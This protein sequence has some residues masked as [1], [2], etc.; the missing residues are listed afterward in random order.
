MPS[1]LSG[2]QRG[3]ASALPGCGYHGPASFEL[4]RRRIF[5]R[6]WLCLGRA[7]RPVS[8]VISSSS[9]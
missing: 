7:S 5:H 4:E 1:V 6:K 8:A 2:L 3:V 9:T